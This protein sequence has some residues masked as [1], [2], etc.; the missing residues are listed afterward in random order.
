MPYYEV[1]L[2]DGMRLQV[3]ESSLNGCEWTDYR[4][5]LIRAARE[6]QRA[7]PDADYAT[8]L[9]MVKSNQQPTTMYGRR[10]LARWQLQ[11]GKRLQMEVEQLGEATSQARDS[12]VPRAATAQ[13]HGPK[14]TH[15]EG[16]KMTDGRSAT[17]EVPRA[18][19]V[20]PQ[21]TQMS[22]RP[23]SP[24]CS[25]VVTHMQ[26]V[27]EPPISARPRSPSRSYGI[28]H[29]TPAIPQEPP[30]TTQQVDNHMTADT[31]DPYTTCAEPTWPAD[32]S[33][34]PP[35]DEVES[36]EMANE[37]RRAHERVDE[38]EETSRVETS[39]DEATTTTPDVPPRTSLK[40]E[41]APQASDGS[42]E[43]TVHEPD[44]AEATRDQGNQ[45]PTTSAST[46]SVSRDHPT[47]TET[48]TDPARLSE[49]PVDMT[50]NDERR[51]DAPTE[52]PDKPEGT[53]GRGGELRVEEVESRELEAPRASRGCAGGTDDDGETRQPGKLT[54]PPDSAEECAQSPDGAHEPAYQ[55]IGSQF[56]QG[57]ELTRWQ[58]QER[59][60]HERADAG[61]NGEVLRASRG[62]EATQSRGRDQARWRM[63][64]RRRGLSQTISTPQQSSTTYLKVP[65]THLHR[66]TN[67]RSDRTNPRAL[68]SRGRRSQ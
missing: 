24:S 35:D 23:R 57:G 48:T 67:L 37:D 30:T 11:V 29:H 62:V 51:P 7:T 20:Q 31:A 25:Y 44:E 39:E 18:A 28:A 12:E 54:R 63:D 68:S 34:D 66:Q 10:C 14:P 17:S 8:V 6:A 13:P 65:Q 40:G 33:Q 15:Q 41:C 3:S 58:G 56:D 19:T 5:I 43:L 27:D 16:G 60:T 2:E 59:V 38:L 26:G 50:G 45:P 22:A 21:T 36:G 53:G 9:A 4:E 55:P 61:V 42:A 32:E 64:G 1:E 49:N 47:D 46:P 52:P